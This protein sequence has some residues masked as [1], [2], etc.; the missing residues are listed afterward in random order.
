L[1]L[2]I[3]SD[4]KESV[5]LIWLCNEEKVVDTELK[6]RQSEKVRV[7]GGAKLVA[8][9]EGGWCNSFDKLTC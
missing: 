5:A 2:R 9:R 3:D 7:R 6:V 1:M 4:S 8:D